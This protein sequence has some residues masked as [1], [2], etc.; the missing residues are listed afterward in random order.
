MTR[1][2]RIAGTLVLTALAVAYL[3]WKIDLG[4]TLDVLAETDL[5][6]FAVL[7]G[8]HGA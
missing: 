5:A 2:V 6:W 4:T 3:V 7:G 8:D 1:R